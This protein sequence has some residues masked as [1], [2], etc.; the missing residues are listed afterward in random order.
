MNRGGLTRIVDVTDE[1]TGL[2]LRVWRRPTPGALYD[3]AIS[4]HLG[5]ELYRYAFAESPEAA[6]ESAVDYVRVSL[7]LGVAAS[8]LAANARAELAP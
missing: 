2:N 1:N 6:V 8:I 4:N 3:A 5:R 7:G